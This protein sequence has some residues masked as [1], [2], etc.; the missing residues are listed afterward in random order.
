M[1][2]HRQRRASSRVR[3]PADRIQSRPRLVGEAAFSRVPSLRCCNQRNAKPPHGPA[4]EIT[5]WPVD[6]ATRDEQSPRR[7]NAL[8]KT[9]V[10]QPA[11]IWHSRFWHRGRQNRTVVLIAKTTCAF[12]QT[13]WRDKRQL[14]RWLRRTNVWRRATNPAR[15]PK[16]L[17]SGETRLGFTAR[18]GNCERSASTGYCDLT[19][20]TVLFSSRPASR[21]PLNGALRRSQTDGFAISQSDLR[22]QLSR[23]LSLRLAGRRRSQQTRFANCMDRPSNA[24]GASRWSG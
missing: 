15:G 4:Q 22:N 16:R 21:Y 20:A 11:G 14:P 3:R 1:H 2:H 23:E 19:E 18:E 24:V 6:P 9:D 5:D 13:S 10:D 8:S 7:N 12:P 17:R